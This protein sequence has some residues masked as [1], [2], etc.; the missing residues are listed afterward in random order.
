MKQVRYRIGQYF[1]AL[2]DK[3]DEKGLSRAREVLSPQLFDLFSQML[4]FEQAHAVRVLNE[5]EA[6][7]H[8]DS[9]LLQA[10]LLHD[11]G[12]ARYPLRPWERAFAVILRKITPAL[13]EKWGQG[14]P[15]GLRAGLAVKAQHAA[16]GSE[17][18]AEAG[19]D[20]GV[21]WLIHHHQDE[22]ISTLPKKQ[23]SLLSIL[24]EADARS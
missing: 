21:L 6:R 5:I 1:R 3:P 7:G 22:D 9:A 16:W 8:D 23:Q 19:A 24:Q 13:A 10:A 18:A 20:E 2:G 4:P 12:K 17:M 14:E 15:I 11:V